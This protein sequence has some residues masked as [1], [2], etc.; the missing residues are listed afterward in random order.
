MQ[1]LI[2]V[3]GGFFHPPPPK[4]WHLVIAAD[5]GGN[6]LFHSQ[7]PANKLI[8]DMDSISK[9]ALDYHE[10]RGA[11]ILRFPREKDFSDFEL[12]LRTLDENRNNSVHLIG[13]FG[14]LRD[15]EILNLLVLSRFVECGIFTFDTSEGCGGVIGQGG[16]TVQIPRINLRSSIMALSPTVHVIESTGSKWK[17]DNETIELGQSRGLSNILVHP[18]WRIKVGQ[19][20][21]LWFIDGVFHE[22]VEIGWHP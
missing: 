15:H 16:M 9:E 7:I 18:Q 2:A 4:E 14:G 17:L 11:E 22:E 12:V 21:L 20:V 10:K 5:S 3:G 13:L 8:G 1:I 19:G 6:F